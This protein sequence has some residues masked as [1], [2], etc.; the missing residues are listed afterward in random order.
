MPDSFPL[1]IQANVFRREAVSESQKF[2][3]TFSGLEKGV[4]VMVNM[5]VKRSF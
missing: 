2:V 4:Q 5:C 1:S 3:W